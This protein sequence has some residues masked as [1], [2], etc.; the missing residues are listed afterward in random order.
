MKEPGVLLSEEE[1]D[2]WLKDQYPPAMIRSNHLPRYRSVC[3]SPSLSTCFFPF[4]PVAVLCF[5][6]FFQLGM[7]TVPRNMRRIFKVR[8]LMLF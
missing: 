3:S 4:L 6:P 8:F 7:S 1:L 5:S 2:V